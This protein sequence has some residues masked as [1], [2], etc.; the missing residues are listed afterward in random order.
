MRAAFCRVIGLQYV[1]D[2]RRTLRLRNPPGTILVGA[3][4][5][6]S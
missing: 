6:D 1:T 2:Q 3:I 5:R 4:F